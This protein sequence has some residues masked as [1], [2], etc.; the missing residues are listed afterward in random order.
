MNSSEPHI[1]TILDEEAGR[2]LD[3]I[4]T[5]RYK[6]EQ[7]RSYFQQLIREGH[8]L[9]NDSIVK[10]H[11]RPNSGDTVAITFKKPPEISLKPETILL[12][13]LYEDDYLI[14]VNKPAGM[15]VHPAPGNWEGTFV[16][17]LL[18][19]C[20]SLQKEV[21][22]LR[23]GVVHRLDK[24]TSGAL[25]AAKNGQVQLRLAALFAGRHVK[26]EYLAVCL[27]N[28]GEGT[29]NLPIGRHPVDRKKMAI[30]ESGGREAITHYQTL[31]F[32]GTLS[33]VRVQIE[34]GRTHQIRVHLKEL[35][36]PILGDE[37]YG[38]SSANH[39]YKAE[40]Q[41]LHAES[42]ELTHPETG[43]LLQL[44]APLSEDMLEVVEKIKKRNQL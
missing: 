8:V 34:T 4:L 30:R 39:H 16:N 38:N 13:I 6:E 33:V 12:E 23:P 5:E 17:A 11:F 37:V 19:H 42:L 36:T 3:L 26:K 2:R 1:V 18:A 22:N 41:L 27:G 9:V 10:K 15:V 29:L 21:Y 31:A 44:R 25:I 32:D 20:E 43:E 14:A 7:S 28:P 40:R 35:R 24:N